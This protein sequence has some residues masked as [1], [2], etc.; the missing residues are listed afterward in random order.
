MSRKCCL[1]YVWKIHLLGFIFVGSYIQY[2]LCAICR[3]IHISL[4]EIDGK[5]WFP[6]IIVCIDLYSIL[7]GGISAM[8]PSLV[9]YAVGRLSSDAA[10]GFH[11]PIMEIIQNLLLLHKILALLLE[12][13]I[14]N[15]WVTT[16][17]FLLLKLYVFTGSILFDPGICF[18]L[19]WNTNMHLPSPLSCSINRVLVSLLIL[20]SYSLCVPH[21]VSIAK[22]SQP[23]TDNPGVDQHMS[24]WPGAQ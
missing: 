15:N 8:K 12:A 24:T 11:D 17:S 14:V 19:L 18:S 9:T 6:K 23:N 5:V 4:I 20:L 22:P 13:Q 2:K 3:F 21:I 1:K 16:L 7:F 10:S